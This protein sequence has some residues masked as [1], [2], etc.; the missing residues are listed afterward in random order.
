MRHPPRLGDPV[1]RLAGIGPKTAAALAGVK[2][3]RV[4]DLLLH[5]PRRYEDRGAVISVAAALAVSGPVLVR[6]RLTCG[7]GRWLRRGLH[8]ADGELVD[9]TGRLPVRW[10]NQPWQ[11]ERWGDGV[12]AVV[13][14]AVGRSRGGRTQLVNPEITVLDGSEAVDDLAPVYPRA[15]ALGGRRLI[16]AVQQALS[17]IDDLADPLPGALRSEVGLPG[18][19]TA[20][21][22]LHRP[23]APDSAEL[24]ARLVERLNS[25]TSPGHRRL[26]FDELLTF[27]AVVES[28]RA[29]RF[30]R[31]TRAIR[32]A[33]PVTERASEVLPFELTAAQRRVL[34]EIN[35]DLARTVPMARLLQGDVGSGKTAVAALTVLAAV[36]GGRQASVM[37]PTELL[38]EQLH[39]ELEWSLGRVG[40]EV[41]LLTGSTT[42]R[43]ARTI[44]S[45]LADGDLPVVV[46]THALFQEGVTF[47]DL[48][49]VV[50]DEQHRFGVGQRQ[51][52]VDKG[53]TP[54]LLVM[55][56]TPIPRSLALTF[57]GDLDLSVIDELPPGRRPVRTA[58]RRPDARDRVLRFLRSEI[59][60]G[61]QGYIVYPIIEASQRVAAAALTSHE[62]MVRDALGGVP[63]G[64]LHG[65]LD[66]AEQ[67]AVVDAF[68]RRELAV[69]LA[70]TVVEVGVDVPAASV[71]VVESAERFGLA[72]LHQ[73]R[74][75]VGRGRRRSWCVLI[76]GDDVSDAA[77][78]RLAVLERSHDGFE[79]AEADLRHRGPGELTGV[80]Q[81][82]AEDLRFADLT[83]D[84]GLAMRARSVARE[85]GRRGRLDGVRDALL[86]LHPVGDRLS[87]A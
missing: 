29:R 66:R 33:V 59:E 25:R 69:L 20:L 74:G 62:A 76:T 39:H 46:G 6:G 37:A 3:R 63:V 27:A 61:G 19:G 84:H 16:A 7:P 70:T 79:I 1:D 53:D 9:D 18:L 56:A 8:I 12:D 22:G 15:A 26:A 65:R 75:R 24:R 78:E 52:L 30:D 87:V 11:V 32:P 71:M 73:L 50:I 14:G 17:C 45:R 28:C 48:G 35:C 36:D 86:E 23:V 5:L 2:I 47:A 38:A 64:V 41:R 77:A 81:W 43:D 83:R 10:F 67:Q 55:T 58:I 72:Q 31:R 49:L 60:A 4:V 42:V 54:H 85:L 40:R 44:R 57:Y 82:G 51:R 68:R 80:R 13:F 34:D 21:L